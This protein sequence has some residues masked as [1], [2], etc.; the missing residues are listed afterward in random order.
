MTHNTGDTVFSSAAWTMLEPVYSGVFLFLCIIGV[1][2]LVRA[3]CDELID[4]TH[5]LFIFIVANRCACKASEYASDE[6]A[7][8]GACI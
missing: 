8:R 7:V 6:R 4:D 3:M 1:Y 2:V 5:F